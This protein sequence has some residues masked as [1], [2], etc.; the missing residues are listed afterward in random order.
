MRVARTERVEIAPERRQDQHVGIVQRAIHG[1]AGSA[2]GAH[3]TAVRA[4]R[5]GFECRFELKA[6]LAA[7]AQASHMEKSLACMSV[8]AKTPSVANMLT[9]WIEARWVIRF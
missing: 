6:E 1:N 9:R 3:R 5:A 7:V 2:E 4:D 8:E